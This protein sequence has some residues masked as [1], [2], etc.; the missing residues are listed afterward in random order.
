VRTL[1]RAKTSENAF[2]SG[3]VYW[4]RFGLGIA[5]G[6]MCGILRLGVEGLVV[7]ASLY[8]TSFLVLL[9]AYH[10]RVG[11]QGRA[12]YIIGLGTYLAVWL[13][14]W[15]LLNTLKAY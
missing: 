5:A 1:K 11:G 10:I 3:Q 7:G 9:L 15:I 2:P 4:T 6:L 13:T 8:F 12:Y 14:T